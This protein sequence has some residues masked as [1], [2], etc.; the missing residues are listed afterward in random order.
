MGHIGALVYND[1]MNKISDFIRR[2]GFYNSLV[3]IVLLLIVGIVTLHVHMSKQIEM[4]QNQNESI[5]SQI[6]SVESHIAS[7]TRALAGSIDETRNEIVGDLQKEKQNVS[8]IT[9]ELGD[10]KKEVG[11]LSGTLG[12]I[13]KL[14]KIDEEL[15]QKYSKVAFLN[16][17]YKPVQLTE[18]PEEYTYSSHKTLQVH[19][20]I[21]PYLLDMFN[22][23]QDDGIDLYGFSAFR[24]FNE[25]GALK[26]QYTLLY[27]A[28]TAN[29]FSADQGYSEHQLGTTL[30]FMTKGIGGTLSGFD[31]TEAYSWMQENAYK[32]GFTLSYPKN[33]EFYI[34][35]PWHWRFVGVKLAKHL[36]KT[37]QEFYEM[38]QR[39]IDTYLISLFD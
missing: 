29:Q 16:E 18:I 24:S 34:F 28:G 38:D 8:K 25:Q 35:E 23:A 14:S 21:Y 13:E 6:V 12:D 36:H 17:H 3:V 15:L 39:D 22:A 1:E 26:G 10:Y 37:D 5:V 4:L 7:T 27:G 20:G 33:N 32:Y 9:A 19:S 30:D 11:Q 31:S 2:D